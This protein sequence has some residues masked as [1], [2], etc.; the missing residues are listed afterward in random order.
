MAVR[1]QAQVYL[2]GAGPGDP[3]LL[4]VKALRVIRDA[5]VVIYDRLISAGILELIPTG[6][7]RF[8]VGKADSRHSLCQDEINE[9]LVKLARGGHRVVRLKGGDPLVFGRGSEEAEYLAR[10]QV[11]FEIVPGVTAAS[12]C[13]AALGI[14]LT[15]RGLATGVRF[16]TGHCRD[17]RALD[18][19]WA[20]LAD[21][22]TT[23]VIYMG[24]ANLAE[25]SRRLI[26]A[27]LPP[28]TP[29]AVIASGT[30]AEQAECRGGLAALPAL[31]AAA[32]L[33]APA[34]IVV[35]RVVALADSLGRPSWRAERLF[36]ELELAGHV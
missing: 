25:I 23:L 4:T 31:A 28:E 16:V 27:G 24:L 34:L 15:H 29:G 12:G 18:L 17:N 32:Q 33:Q 20:S 1:Q 2:V 6:I 21:P 19:N 11:P 5:E 26:E 22:D 10:H 14:P 7:A 3:D 35:G 9:L 8:Y 30:T 13:T 36:E